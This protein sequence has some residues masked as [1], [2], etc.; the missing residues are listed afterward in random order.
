M[1]DERIAQAL[2]QASKKDAVKAAAMIREYPEVLE[3]HMLVMRAF[4]CLRMTMHTGPKIDYDESVAGGYQGKDW[5]ISCIV[6]DCRWHSDCRRVPQA[7]STGRGA[8]HECSVRI[9]SD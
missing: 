7:M 9:M 4:E 8:L 5:A 1:T 3:D 6:N 2:M